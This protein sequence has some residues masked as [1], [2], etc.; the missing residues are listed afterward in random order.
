MKPT[1][2]SDKQESGGST[3]RTIT[4]KTTKIDDK[5]DSNT[6]TIL[7][8]SQSVLSK[9]LNP[10]QIGIQSFKKTDPS[11]TTIIATSAGLNQSILKVKNLKQTAPPAPENVN[12]AQ[13]TS[14]YNP[15]GVTT[16]NV[17]TGPTG[18]TTKPALKVKKVKAEPSETTTENAQLAQILTTLANDTDEENPAPAKTVE[19][20]GLL[21]AIPEAFSKG[22]VRCLCKVGNRVWTAGSFGKLA[23]YDTEV[24]FFLIFPRNDSKSDSFLKLN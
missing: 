2:N 24:L 19:V 14:V 23:I 5:S 6:Q 18:G 20:G 13:M 15:S 22:E 16:V 11:V 3:P 4:L 1:D 9:T 7:N 10:S 21:A 17:G 8:A 12:D